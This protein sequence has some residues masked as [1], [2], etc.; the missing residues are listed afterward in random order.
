MQGTSH[1]NNAD[2]ASEDGQGTQS[3]A[4]A[5][6]RPR[7]RPGKWKM[8]LLSAVIVVVI[9]A[10]VLSIT[11]TLK[12]SINTTA[13]TTLVQ[14]SPNGRLLVSKTLESTIAVYTTSNCLN[15]YPDSYDS[16]YTVKVWNPVS[17]T[18]LY[19]FPASANTDFG[20]RIQ[21]SPDG[22]LL[23]TSSTRLVSDPS[24]WRITL[25]ESQ[26]GTLLRTLAVDQPF[27]SDFAFSPDSRWLVTGS[28]Y[29]TFHFWTAH[30][31]RIRD[32]QSGVSIREL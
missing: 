10:I 12:A 28:G 8:V 16:R 19:S 21:F 27:V 26:H 22:R 31:I 15:C 23:A 20:N 3:A 25:R 5:P 24:L 6:A 9:L 2:N 4:Q 17:N 11:F 18:L 1:D 32:V 14:F 13:P 29:T 30:T 7:R